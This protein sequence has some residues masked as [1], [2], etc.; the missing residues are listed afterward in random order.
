MVE[1]NPSRLIANL[2]ALGTFG[3]H[4]PG[5]IRPSLSTVDMESRRWLVDRMAEAGLQA[6]IDGVGNVIGKSANSGQAL[7]I[8]SHTDT[9]PR[10]GWLDGAMGVIYGLEVAHALGESEH[11]RHLAVDVVSW[12]DEEGTY[13]GCLGSRSFCGSLPP[14]AMET[15]TSSQGQRLADAIAAAGLEG[16][17]RMRFEDG[18]YRGHIEA[19]IEQG[20]YLEETG[21]QIGVVTSIVGIRGFRITF[22]GEQ[23]H[24]GTT[25]MARRKDA[26]V[27]LI[28]FC[29]QIRQKFSELAGDTTVWTIGHVTFDPG[30]QSIVPGK[31][32]ML[33]QFRDPSEDHLVRLEQALRGIA[34]RTDAAG[35]VA[36]SVVSTGHHSVPTIM[37]DGLQKHIADA[38]QLHAPGSWMHMPSAA[39]HDGMVLADVMPCAMLFV[40]SIGGISHDFA[41]DTS[42]EDI[43]A[44]CRVLATAAASILSG[45]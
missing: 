24:A 11:T 45:D 17:P 7:L 36:V 2:R 30:A 42:E 5:V 39:G 19:H 40:P 35:P 41:E 31:A 16:L 18:R 29:H 26:G 13:F 43:V 6:T 8:G 44:G 4:E 23:N 34:E 32:E 28:E 12:I 20:P 10:G 3:T 9:Q 38:A 27:A 14:D 25:P 33:F 22:L 21:N 15:A 1:I 37:D